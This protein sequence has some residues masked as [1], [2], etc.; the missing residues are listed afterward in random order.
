VHPPYGIPSRELMIKS[1]AD[2]LYRGP[3]RPTQE[4][5]DPILANFN[6]KKDL[7]LALPESI[8]AMT[9]ET[10]SDVKSYLESFYSSIKNTKDVKRLFV[11][12]ESGGGCD[13]KPTM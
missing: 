9:K 3:C 12:K 10:R 2:R 7:I 1:V 6:A 11:A 5:V 8:S 4:L 13:S